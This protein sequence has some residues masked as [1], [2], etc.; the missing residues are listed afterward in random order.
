MSETAD[1]SRPMITGAAR[2]AGVMGWPVHHSLS[3]R[4]HG[5]WLNHYGVDGA[6]VP[7]AVHPEHLSAAIAGLRG[8]GFAGAN[9]T[10]PHKE[11]VMPLLASI[12]PLALQI[13]A[14][15]TLIV[16][17]DGSVHGHNTDAEGYLAS[18]GGA[19]DVETLRHAVILGAGGAA[20]AVAAGLL[21][22]GVR[23]LTLTNR[24][25]ARA[26]ALA[27]HLG[28]HEGAV[29]VADWPGSQ[30]DLH[31]A[32]LLVNTTSL[33]MDGQ[34]PLLVDL[35]GLPAGAVVS[36]IVYVPLETDLLARARARGHRVVD[37]LGMLLHQA[38]AGFEAWF[39]VRPEVTRDLRAHVLAG[40]EKGK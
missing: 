20:R 12:S 3:P 1:L 27:A 31:D 40:L 2:V 11:T 35:E 26:E 19:V 32:D 17:Q 34:P 4:L 39:G 25:R 6:Y 24:T 7:L 21:S 18:L 9:V 30:Q 5:Y 10:V 14:V 33:G 15:N 36:D 13:G 23:R 22:R 29:R 38:G 28:R 16:S 8:L 37:G